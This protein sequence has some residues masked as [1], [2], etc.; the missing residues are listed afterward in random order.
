MCVRKLIILYYKFIK[1]IF[2]LQYIELN[3]IIHYYPQISL[4]NAL[5]LLLRHVLIRRIILPTFAWVRET[6]IPRFWFK[7]KRSFQDPK[8]RQFPYSSLET[9]DF[10]KT[11]RFHVQERIQ[12]EQ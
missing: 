5:P 6:P 9:N 4:S 8:V 10:L 2:Y 3:E 7:M 11:A 12:C 1:Y